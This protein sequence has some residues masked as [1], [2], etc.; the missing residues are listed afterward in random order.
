MEIIIGG[1]VL[2]IAFIVVI[3]RILAFNDRRYTDMIAQEEWRAFQQACE[4]RTNE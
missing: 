1:A 4:K 3:T 2:W